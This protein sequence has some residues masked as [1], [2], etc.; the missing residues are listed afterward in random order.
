MRCSKLIS[1]FTALFEQSVN[2]D[3]CV[4]RTMSPYTSSCTKRFQAVRTAAISLLGTLHMYVG[5]SLRMFF[6]EE[7]P[8]L[9]QQIDAEFEKVHLM[10]LFI[11]MP[12][13]WYL[14]PL[15]QNESSSKTSH[16]KLSLNCM[17]MN[18]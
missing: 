14:V 12:F 5:A 6:E 1:L 18:Q 7:K 17:K 13:P 4:V 10:K 3:E 2:I 9:L 15:F 16:M 11:N 8:A